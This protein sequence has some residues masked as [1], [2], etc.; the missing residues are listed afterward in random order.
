MTPGG[1]TP[2]ALPPGLPVLDI[3]EIVLGG[4]G[5]STKILVAPAVLTK[6]PAVTVVDGLATRGS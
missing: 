1:V 2:F 4:G 3:D 6:L 5:R